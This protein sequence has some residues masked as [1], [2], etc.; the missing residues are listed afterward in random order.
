MVKAR[1][2][3]GNFFSLLIIDSQHATYYTTSLMTPRLSDEQIKSFLSSIFANIEEASGRHSWD[4]FFE[5]H[6]GP[7]STVAQVDAS[8][9]AYVHRDKFLLFQFSD[10]GAD[11]HFP[12][13]GFAVLKRFMDSLTD[14]MADKDWGMY[15]NFLDTQLDGKAAQQ[16]YWGDNLPRLRSIKTQLDPH[17]VFWNPQGISPLF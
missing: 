13:E 5:M 7:K 4:I 6:G 2:G 8:A 15:A 1:S 3:W 11:G 17:D 12:T 10:V 14:S 9:T 16:L